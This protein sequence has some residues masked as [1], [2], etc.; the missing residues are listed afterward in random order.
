M[1]K[2][3]LLLLI[4]VLTIGSNFAQITDKEGALKTVSKDTTDGWEKGGMFA[5]TFG[6]SNF[7]N[8][9]AGGI[10]TLSL[11]G[12][13][14]LFANYKQGKLTWD[15]NLDLGYGIQKQGKNS[16]SMIM[17]TDDRL[18]FASKLGLKATDKLYY[19]ALLDFKTQFTNG[20]NYPNDS[21]E[22]SGFLA[23]GYL[24]VALGID[25]RPNKDLSVFVAPL[26]S[27]T[28]IVN[29]QKLANI[30][31]FGVDSAKNIRNEF[32][33]YLKAVYKKEVVKNV[34]LIT[35]LGLFSNYL[36]N[37][38]NIDVDW[39]VLLGMKINKYIT[40][41]LSTQ[42]LYDHDIDIYLQDKDGLPTGEVSKR[43]QFKEI[44]GIG[45]SVKF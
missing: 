43:I 23:P 20:Y 44:L 2:I 7:T 29:N 31:A 35:K 38:Q 13:V 10:N 27:K 1:K 14:G 39:E 12:L 34:S 6:Q 25:Y 5:L 18:N 16:S 36:N 11:N 19:A 45:F 9:A 40:A 22:I 28:T 15:N 3:T 24:L 21:V 33:G 26:T 42:L 41:N 4:A 8:W 32:G 30:G 37:P 17:K